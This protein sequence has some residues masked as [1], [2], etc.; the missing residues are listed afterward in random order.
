[1]EREEAARAPEL[2]PAEARWRRRKEARPGEILDAALA[3]FAARGFAAARMEDIAAR[4]GVTKGTLYLYFASKEELFKSLVRES[5]GAVIAARRVEAD[6]YQGSAS[7]LL[8][9]V[10]R[11]MG[12]F[13]RTSDRAVLPKIIMAEAGNFP[14][15]LRFYRAEVVENGLALIGGIIARGIAQ[16]EFR[17]VDPQHAARLCVAP[18]LLVILWRTTFAREETTPYDLE[19]LVEAHIDTLLS[20]L[21]P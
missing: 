11:F 8:A 5:I 19:G 13:A 17:P 15:L 18:L 4:A 1:M 3:E 21:A 9:T 6:A 20:G 12:Y 14:E 10:L 7:D 2:A 16:G